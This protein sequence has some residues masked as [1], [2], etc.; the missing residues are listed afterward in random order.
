MAVIFPNWKKVTPLVL[1]VAIACRANCYERAKRE[2]SVFFWCEKSEKNS[3]F[4]LGEKCSVILLDRPLPE[5]YISRAMNLKWVSKH[6]NICQI[7]LGK[8]SNRINT[9]KL[10]HEFVE[11][12]TYNILWMNCFL[13][14]SVY[15]QLDKLC[16]TKIEFGALLN[17]NL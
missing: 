17:C 14:V 11:I 16:K 7:K 5:P 12:Y 6:A 3:Q 15:F 10:L 4:F 2:R 13:G 9:A 1:H 8:F